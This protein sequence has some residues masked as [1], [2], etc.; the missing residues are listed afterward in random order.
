M[1]TLLVGQQWI[2]ALEGHQRTIRAELASASGI[3]V[4]Y[5]CRPG[6]KVSGSQRRAVVDEAKVSWSTALGGHVCKR[7]QAARVEVELE[8]VDGTS[9]CLDRCVNCR[10]E[11]RRIGEPCWARSRLE[12]GD[13]REGRWRC[14]RE[15]KRCD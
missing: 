6:A 7:R 2:R 3:K 5:E 13:E 11:F 4:D 9:V 8:R 14:R 10:W 15:L 12:L 1:W